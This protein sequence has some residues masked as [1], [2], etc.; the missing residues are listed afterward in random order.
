MPDPIVTHLPWDSEFF[1]VSIARATVDGDSVETAAEQ[2]AAQQVHCLYLFVQA[3]RPQAI[4]DALRRGGRLVDLR[5]GLNLRTPLPLPEGVRRAD[6][7]DIAALVPL[8]QNLASASRFSADSRFPHDAV[9][10]MYDIWLDRCLD[11]GIVVVPDHGVDS[12]VGARPSGDET[13]SIDLVYVGAQ[14]RG[15]GLASRLVGGAVATAGARGAQVAT[16]AWNVAAQR[17]YQD[18]GFRTASIQA[19]VHLWLDEAPTGRQ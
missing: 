8:A 1:G 12:F 6:R 15:Q 13:I 5:V 2:A 3:A 11:E 18:A 10:A 4:A 7:R 19:I 16:Q 14:S 17:S 9:K